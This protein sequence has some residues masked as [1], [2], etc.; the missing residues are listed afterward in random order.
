MSQSILEMSE[1][2]SR[3]I[4][5]FVEHGIRRAILFGSYAKG[6]ATKYSDVDIYVDSGLT[7]LRFFFGLVE[8]VNEALGIPVDLI[9]RQCIFEGGSL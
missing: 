7:G 4:P 9:D 3:L 8:D 1:I 2:R 6:C 5:I